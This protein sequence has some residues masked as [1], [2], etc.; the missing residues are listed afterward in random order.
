M[1]NCYPKL[2]LLDLSKGTDPQKFSY[3]QQFA[4]SRPNVEL[5]LVGTQFITFGYNTSTQIT[6]W[7]TTPETA[8]EYQ[9]NVTGE[10]EHRKTLSPYQAYTQNT[11]ANHPWIVLRHKAERKEKF[12]RMTPL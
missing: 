12:P 7:N 6:F 5:V 11:F 4:Q 8:E 2:K 10:R 1:P 9:I 3:Y